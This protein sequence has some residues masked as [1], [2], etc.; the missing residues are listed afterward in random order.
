MTQ[1]AF[2]R[3]A[4][5]QPPIGSV[6][7]G[8][9][10]YQENPGEPLLKITAPEWSGYSAQKNTYK[11]LSTQDMQALIDVVGMFD[12]DARGRR[13]PVTA[14]RASFDGFSVYLP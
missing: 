9:I 1:G 14:G 10:L 3:L 13:V 11:D 7:A 6:T 12:L 5:T 2:Y 8:T 4:D